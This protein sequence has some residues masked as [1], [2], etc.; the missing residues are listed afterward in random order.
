MRSICA[1]AHA[2]CH[3][4][5][6]KDLKV[7]PVLNIRSDRICGIRVRVNSS[8]F[9]LL[10]ILGVY[11]PC[12]GVGLEW[13]RE[14]L[15][16]LENLVGEGERLGAVVIAGDFNAHLGKLG[17][18]RGMGEANQQGVI[19]KD[20]IDRCSLHVLSLSTR[21]EGQNYTFWNSV[22]ETT[23]DYILGD[24]E[25]SCSM[26]CCSTL[27]CAPLNT[28]DHLPITASFRFND[29]PSSTGHWPRNPRA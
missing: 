18:P 9:D 15:E 13:Y 7:S 12:A 19:V 26:V 8:H 29:I 24:Y 25:A 6:R 17:G 14:H 16:E 5:Y 22:S 11:L 10:T 23:V 2:R 21:S 28:S 4:L 20:F 27:E 1:T 3:V